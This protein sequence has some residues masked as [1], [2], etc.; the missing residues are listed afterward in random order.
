M[1]EKKTQKNKTYSTNQDPLEH[2]GN[3]RNYFLQT[4]QQW[5]KKEL[6]LSE[7][8]YL[9]SLLS[10]SGMGWHTLHPSSCGRRTRTAP[11]PAAR[12]GTAGRASATDGSRWRGA[13]LFCGKLEDG[14]PK[15]CKYT[16]RKKHKFETFGLT[17]QLSNA[18]FFSFCVGLYCFL[19]RVRVCVVTKMRGKCAWARPYT[20]QQKNIWNLQLKTENRIVTKKK[21][22]WICF[23]IA[24]G[25]DVIFLKGL[26]RYYHSEAGYGLIHLSLPLL[27]PFVYKNKFMNLKLNIL[28]HCCHQVVIVWHRSFWLIVTVFLVLDDIQIMGIQSLPWQSWTTKIYF[29]FF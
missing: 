25:S 29:F 3:V 15:I 13:D 28:I 10:D 12:G 22:C 2:T 7:L 20:C 16:K 8:S 14:H 26:C 6:C 11:P 9:V 21:N 27:W 18:F 1:G 24:S 17:F 5:T 19:L 23:L 4:T